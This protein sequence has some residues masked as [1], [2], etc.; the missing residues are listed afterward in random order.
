M[1]GLCLPCGAVFKQN[2]S[3]YPLLTGNERA[4]VNEL[5]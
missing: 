5:D 4:C 2:P 1:Q 3:S